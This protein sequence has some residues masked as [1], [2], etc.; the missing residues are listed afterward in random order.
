[1]ASD[2][3]HS[4]V[5]YIAMA[6]S[7]CHKVKSLVAIK[8]LSSTFSTEVWGVASYVAVVCGSICLSPMSDSAQRFTSAVVQRNWLIKWASLNRARLTNIATNI[9]QAVLAQILLYGIWWHLID[10]TAMYRISLWHLRDAIKWK[11]MSRQ[12]SGQA[13]L[14]GRAS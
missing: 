7:G 3:C 11:P 8:Q 5:Q 12:N 4:D 2:R 6:S 13:G 1:M 14:V 10:A 9:A